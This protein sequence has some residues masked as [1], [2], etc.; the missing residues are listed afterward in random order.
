VST[1][2]QSS[3]FQN[4][5]FQIT[6]VVVKKKVGWGFRHT[7]EELEARLRQQKT[8]TFGLR[9]YDDYLAARAAAAKRLEST[10][11]D[12]H[13]KALSE[14]V[15]AADEAIAPETV[16]GITEMLKAAAGAKRLTASL[17]H[18]RALADLALYDDDEE[19]IEMLLLH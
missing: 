17:K 6:V 10:K 5:A 2:F 7:Q 12:P 9:W 14:A 13:R 3:A 1:A 4:N 8:E 16:M 19:V 18:A 15:D 11:S